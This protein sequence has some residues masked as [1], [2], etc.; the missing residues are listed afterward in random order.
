MNNSL[1]F[2]TD[3]FSYSSTKNSHV[4]ENPFDVVDEL[5]A[6][7]KTRIKGSLRRILEH[8]AK[9]NLSNEYPTPNEI[10]KELRISYSTL[11]KT[12][13]RAVGNRL[14]V[15]HPEKKGHSQRYVLY[16]MQDHVISGHST[17]RD[18]D[19]NDDGDIKTDELYQSATIL[20]S[21]LDELIENN[22]KMF[23]N[24]S[25]T[26]ELNDK[27]DY[28]RIEWKIQSQKNKGKVYEFR[29]ARH[30]SGVITIYPNGRVLIDVRCSKE[31]FDLF[32]ADGRN[33]LRVVCGQLLQE[34]IKE[35]SNL[36]PLKTDIPNWQ[37]T[38][39]DGAYD[40]PI[41]DIEDK[42][43]EGRLPHQHAS[44]SLRRLGVLR[45]KHLD[46]IFQIYE[47]MLPTG[48]SLR[49]ERRFSFNEQK[50]TVDSLVN[51]F[52]NS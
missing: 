29:F 45:I 3:S 4:Y 6:L 11:K 10:G 51:S 18:Y 27:D 22:R 39:I 7:R 21:A 46:R 2:N 33:D 38:Q 23:H 9:C 44:I 15:R 31:P 43:N 16:N 28:Y 19:E 40:I 1:N 36:S 26:S 41:R 42:M 13:Q 37:I 49:L 34:L 14:I 47:K 52:T 50:P 5:S 12:L 20:M 17:N 32:I 35:I 25:L 24:I 30:R 8:I 48:P